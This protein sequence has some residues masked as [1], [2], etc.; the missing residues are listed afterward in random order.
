MRCRVPFLSSVAAGLFLFASGSGQAL[1]A[2]TAGKAKAVL[3]ATLVVPPLSA[4]EAKAAYAPVAR[5]RAH[6]AMPMPA[7]ASTAALGDGAGQVSRAEDAESPVPR[8]AP[9]LARPF[10][11]AELA[12]A[13]A[14][15]E[16]PRASASHAFA[17]AEK[18]PSSAVTTGVAMAHDAASFGVPPAGGAADDGQAAGDLAVAAEIAAR[19]VTPSRDPVGAAVAAFYAERSDRPVWTEGGAL[20]QAARAG[21]ERLSHADEEGL[22][23]NAF[24]VPQADRLAG[25]ATDAATIADVEI[26][27]SAVFLDYAQQA[28]DG[29]VDARKISHSIVPAQ[30]LS[31]PVGA[32]N[33]IADATDLAATLE[34]FNPTH[35]QFLALKRKLAE[36]KAADAVAESRPPVV[37]PGPILRVGMEDQR[38]ALLRTRLGLTMVDDDLYDDALAEAVRSFQRERRLKATGILGP[39]T[40]A[41]LNGGFR[42][43]PVSIENEI[44]ANMERW[45]WMPR[46]M[47]ASNVLVN[48]PEYRLRV[49][50][51]GSEVHEAKVIVGKPDT[52]TPMFSDNM[53]FVVFNPSW[54]VPQ[55]IIK[56]EY[57]PKLMEDPDYLA[58][59]GF[60]VTY[61]GDRMTVRQPPGDDNALGHIKF[62]FPNNFSVYLHDT[63]SRSLFANEKRAFSHGCVRVDLPYKFA[64]IVMGAENGWTE[65]RVRRSIGGRERRVDLARPIAVHIAYFTAYVDGDGEL[66][67]FDDIY[68]YDQRVMAA[69]GLSS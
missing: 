31:D 29:R 4:A 49:T 36:L 10:N 58:R 67:F 23:P 15:F 7:P 66:R 12:A 47:G 37:P 35:P 39:Q 55:S 50:M 6:L 60:I 65:D 68:G 3:P 54:N 56:K 24:A 27:L 45:R 64:E 69:L 8:P 28:A 11:K 46:D 59:R 21:L 5:P 61:H 48:V 33:M 18:A 14:R 40:V 1:D 42:R 38:V 30:N 26:A 22:D 20:T 53:E 62:M 43:P 16:A 57:M 17:E 32:L 9:A 44:V 13:R 25:P 41:A 63:S 51:N 19:L 34:A 2:G 52:P